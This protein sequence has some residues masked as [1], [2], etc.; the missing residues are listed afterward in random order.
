[1]YAGTGPWRQRL[2]RQQG[3]CL[4]Y[5]PNDLFVHRSRAMAAEIAKATR[6]LSGSEIKVAKASVKKASML[7]IDE[8]NSNPPCLRIKRSFFKDQK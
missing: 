6:L 3:Y 2:Q 8:I 4:H 1:M 7:D 5:V